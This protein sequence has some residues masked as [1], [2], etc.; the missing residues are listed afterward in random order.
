MAD[1]EENVKEKNM[2]PQLLAEVQAREKEV[3]GLINRRD[4][5][6][7]I[8]AALANPPVAAKDISIKVSKLL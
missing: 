6:G 5:K 8:V 4:K 1:D 2:D 3:N 7:A